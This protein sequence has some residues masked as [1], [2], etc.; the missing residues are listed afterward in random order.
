MLMSKAGGAQVWLDCDLC[1]HSRLKSDFVMQDKWRNLLKASFAQTPA[2]EGV[3]IYES[4][5]YF[6]LVEVSLI[7]LKHPCVL[8]ELLVL[9][10]E[11]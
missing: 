4:N 5:L 11:T 7:V 2:D 1:A 9:R 3:R 6:Y 10:V 8:C